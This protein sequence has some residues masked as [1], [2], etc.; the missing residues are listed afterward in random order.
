MQD[1]GCLGLL[2]EEQSQKTPLQSQQ[3]PQQQEQLQ[4][5]QQQQQEQPN[6][7][8]CIDL[9]KLVAQ[10]PPA[11]DDSGTVSATPAVA[12]D[13]PGS[14]RA[15]VLL[16]DEMEE[17][18]S[19]FQLLQAEHWAQRQRLLAAEADA[20]QLRSAA[21][22]A[23]TVAAEVRYVLVGDSLHKM[24]PAVPRVYNKQTHL[25]SLIMLLRRR[26]RMWLMQIARF[27]ARRSVPCGL[28]LILWGSSH[29]YASLN[30]RSKHTWQSYGTQKGTGARG[31]HIHDAP[32]G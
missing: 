8:L 1:A 26:R 2:L 24:R 12:G 32:A 16:Q 15:L 13:P 25:P 11:A 31:L 29:G 23:A 21:A 18:R 5:Q 22:A 3:Q 6:Q 19:C 4:S 10:Q 20:I 7:P 27:P 14:D 30:A 9:T 28:K 17:L